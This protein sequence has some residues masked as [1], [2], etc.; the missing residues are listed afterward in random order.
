MEGGKQNRTGLFVAVIASEL[1]VTK[2]QKAPTYTLPV[3]QFSIDKMS[4]KVLATY[5]KVL[6]EGLL[7]NYQ[8]L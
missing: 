5:L 3:P 4:S 2:E 7:G 1:H 6:L 8:T